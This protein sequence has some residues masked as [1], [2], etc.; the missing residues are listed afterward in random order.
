MNH[1]HAFLNNH[2]NLLQPAQIGYHGRTF[3]A[4]LGSLTT[5]GALLETHALTLP[6][7]MEV[8]LSL[9]LGRTSW[10]I[11]AVITHTTPHEIGVLFRQPQQQLYDAA[12]DQLPL[13]FQPTRR[14]APAPSARF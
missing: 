7:G 3:S 11:K 10:Q 12:H 5:D 1:S 14:H 9:T 8:D 2:I 4:T 13:S 6:V